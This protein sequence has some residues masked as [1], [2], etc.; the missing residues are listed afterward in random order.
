[1]VVGFS[2]GRLLFNEMTIEQP[3]LK[4]LLVDYRA[5]WLDLFCTR[6]QQ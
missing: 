4:L 2:F 5:G 6:N 3:A 1:M